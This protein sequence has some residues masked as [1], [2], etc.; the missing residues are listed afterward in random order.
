MPLNKSISPRLALAGRS[1][2]LLLLLALGAE[3]RA[4]TIPNPSFES[5]GVFATAP[6]Y[7]SGNA[8]I[9]SWTGSPTNRVGLNPA[10]A[11]NDFANN[12]AVPNGT[13]VAFIQSDSGITSTLSTTVT[14]LVV[15]TSYRVQFRAN[16]RTGSTAP[17]AAYRLNGGAPVSFSVDPPVGGSNPYYTISGIFTATA[18]TAALEIR[19]TTTTESTVLVDN[20]SITAATA[21]Q[22]TNA[23]NDGPGSLRQALN[24]AAA[25]PAC[26]IITFAAALSGQTIT[27]LG[28]LVVNDA[29]GVIID[30]SALGAGITVSGGD[31]TR[32]FSVTSSSLV[33]M[34]KLTLTLGA[35][36]GAASDGNGGAIYNAG[37][38]ALAGCTLT[39]NRSDGAGTNGGAIYNDAGGNLA[40]TQCTFFENSADDRGGAINSQPSA[41]LA[42][43]HCTISGNTAA[44]ET[45]IRNAGAFTVTNSVI[46]DS[47]YNTSSGSTVLAGANLISVLTSDFSGPGISGAP[48]NTADPLLGTLAGNGGPTRT[49]ALLPGSP[50]R[51]A[52]AVLVPA[53][54]SDQRGKAIL[55]VPDIGAFENQAGGTF[56]F[57]ATGYSV[58]ETAGPAVVTINRTG[59]FDGAASVKIS[60]TAGTATAADFTAVSLLTVS[61][62]DGVIT[63]DVPITIA[64][65]G[66]GEAN[67]TFTVTLSA[68]T[69]AGTALAA[70]STAKVILVDPSSIAADAVAPGLPVIS[71]PLANASVNAT[72][73]GP[74]IVTGTAADNKGVASVAL[75]DNFDNLLADATLDTPNATSTGWSATITPNAGA[76][77]IKAQSAD[78]GGNLS[79][80]ATRSFK[81]R[82]PLAVEIAGNGSVTAGF[83]PNSFRDV[84]QKYLVTA[85]PAAAPAP[86]NIFKCWTIQS[87]HSTGELGMPLTA[88]EK[89][90]LNF[91]HREGLVLRANF[92]PNPYPLLGANSAGVSGVEYNGLIHANPALPGPNGSRR[93]NSTEG[94]LTATV[95]S[96]GAFSGKL[97]ID[98]SVLNMAG[99]FDQN[100]VARFGTS[101]ATTFAVARVNKPSLVV[102]LTIDI[103]PGRA[104]DTL[105]GTVTATGFQRSVILA[106]SNA[107]ADRAFYDGLT[108]AT[109]VPAAYLGAANATQAY[110]VV[111]P[112]RPPFGEDLIAELD[113]DPF[114]DLSLPDGA[115][116]DRIV[117]QDP[118]PSGLT[119]GEI[120]TLVNQHDGDYF[121]LEDSMGDPAPIT[122][123]G[124]FAVT[125]LPSDPDSVQLEELSLARQ[126]YPQG[127]GY[128]FITI[129]KAGVVTLTTG[130]LADGT[131]VTGASKLSKDKTFPLFLQLYNKKG[132]LGGDVALDADNP[133]SDLAAVNLDW[134]R[135]FDSTSHYYPY[136]WEEIIRVGLMG[137]RYA[138]TF[139]PASSVLRIADDAQGGDAN[140]IGDELL[141]ADPDF[142]NG[143]LSYFDGQLTE[144]RFRTVSISTTNIVTKV[145]ASDTSF[146]LT[147]T[148]TTGLFKGTFVHENDEGVAIPLLTDYE[149][150]IYQKG[151]DAGG[152]GYF[153]TRKPTPIDYTGE[154]G[155]VNL[156]G[157]EP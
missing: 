71:S 151:P 150:A 101:R 87:G 72:V 134:L 40:V 141:P 16:S 100:G 132:F 9:I 145:P 110:T 44:A 57:S 42:V 2:R 1:S 115:E 114:F 116:G 117:F 113:G 109:T 54:T 18:T 143:G 25:T 122:E 128:G 50:A 13:R 155:A 41:E 49:M 119:A 58:D 139:T 118:A 111:F 47:V 136:G 103:S 69:G 148:P 51:N 11:Q 137:A 126:D 62:P 146:T 56:V 32:I 79:N 20:F 14:G 157:F 130:K 78:L 67:E 64:N 102:A 8:A 93:D 61:F 5:N 112:S 98:G 89:P 156:F 21:I 70:P 97:T 7:I 6:G 105:S 23:D 55:G 73:G 74:L 123:D 84:G 85:S 83:S 140:L 127:D 38:L 133:A 19:N 95:T 81:V 86:G 12:G 29:G 39:G 60:T 147:L 106:V 34:R 28:E 26:N 17:A 149:G 129:S 77:T 92:V 75:Y 27:L 15:G 107:T 52:A 65:D 31:I 43:T 153:L 144:E 82:R 53:I 48:N 66:S 80:F 152:Y 35:G 76:N 99:A 3:L 94:L 120:Y 45:G 22:V 104:K 46:E 59:G 135:P 33:S 154:S 24:A 90:A 121:Y 37:R 138:A 30:A 36:E 131:V 96:T 124:D 68:P 125:R 142:G 108:P 91:I 88:L 63:Q 4:Q 10:G